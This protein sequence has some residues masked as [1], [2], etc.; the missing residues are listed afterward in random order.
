MTGVCTCRLRLIRPTWRA[1]NLDGSTKT[2]NPSKI[3]AIGK[4][5][6]DGKGVE[7]GCCDEKKN[8]TG[9]W[10]VLEGDLE[11]SEKLNIVRSNR[12]MTAASRL[13]RFVWIV[14][15]NLAACGYRWAGWFPMEDCTSPFPGTRD[16]AKN[17]GS[18]LLE[19][20]WLRG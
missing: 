10:K 11:P 15:M 9:C 4:E 1:P 2:S 14:H 18:R 17:N 6:T 16:R 13:Q 5:A 8:T 7:N 19:G 3:C 12:D 20:R